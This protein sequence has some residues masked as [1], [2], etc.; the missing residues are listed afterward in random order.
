MK[1]KEYIMKQII[2]KAIQKLYIV[3]CVEDGLSVQYVAI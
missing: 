3:I 2:I 1:I